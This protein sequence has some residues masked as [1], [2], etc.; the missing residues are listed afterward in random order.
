MSI[1]QRETREKEDKTVV[2]A[3]GAFS[4]G[5]FLLGIYPYYDIER[6]LLLTWPLLPLIRNQHLYMEDIAE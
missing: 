3:D 1:Y 2:H 6:F 5:C 4:P